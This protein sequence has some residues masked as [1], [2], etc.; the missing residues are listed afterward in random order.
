[1]TVYGDMSVP[2]AKALVI[3]L[4]TVLNRQSLRR[5]DSPSGTVKNYI[6]A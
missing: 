3:L 6:A 4:T 1:M 2:I 5:Y